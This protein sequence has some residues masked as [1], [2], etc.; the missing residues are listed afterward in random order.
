[1]ATRTFVTTRTLAVGSHQVTHKLTQQLSGQTWNVTV[2]A[3]SL[4]PLAG[5]VLW[6]EDSGDNGTTWTERGVYTI[7]GVDPGEE[8]VLSL[9]TPA[10]RRDLRVRA[11]V[12]G[13]VITLTVDGVT[14]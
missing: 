1:M 4:D 8:S 10:L 6:L 3:S 5:A 2:R 13:A 12:T 9:R 11:T 7:A 14:V